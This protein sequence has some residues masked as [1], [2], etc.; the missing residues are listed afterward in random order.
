MKDILCTRTPYVVFHATHNFPP[1]L[2]AIDPN[3]NIAMDKKL[4]FG[5]MVTLQRALRGG[6]EAEIS[7][8]LKSLDLAP[9]DRVGMQKSEVM[10]VLAGWEWSSYS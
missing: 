4:S 2:T 10:T 1:L 9:N 6:D 5:D 3:I 7:S 8:T